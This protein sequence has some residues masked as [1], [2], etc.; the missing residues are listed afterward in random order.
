MTVNDPL[1][2]FKNALKAEKDNSECI[3]RLYKLVRD[4]GVREC[5]LCCHDN[6]DLGAEN[7]ML[8]F[9]NEQIEEENMVD[10]IV[11]QLEHAGPQLG[12]ATVLLDKQLGTRKSSD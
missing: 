6:Q 2:A 3:K 1:D 8:W 10:A 9:I 7:I 12:I 11:Q 4:K 5:L